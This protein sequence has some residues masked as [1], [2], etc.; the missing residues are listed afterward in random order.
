ME[1]QQ[2]KVL[3]FLLV[4]YSATIYVAYMTAHK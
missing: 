3:A 1:D 4:Y 2:E